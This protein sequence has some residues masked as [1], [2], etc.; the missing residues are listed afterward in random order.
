MDSLE[1]M[2]KFLDKQSSKT[3]WG[4][5]KILTDQSFSNEIDS[6]IKKLP[7]KCPVQDCFTGEFCQ[8]LR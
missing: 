1:E 6:V 5:N 3:E 8:T 2:D 4:R 7:N